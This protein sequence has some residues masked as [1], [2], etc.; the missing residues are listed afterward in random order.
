MDSHEET[1]DTFGDDKI[2]D[3]LSS[4]NSISHDDFVAQVSSPEASRQ[5][6][7]A[8]QLFNCI[9]NQWN[10]NP[11]LPHGETFFFDLLTPDQHLVRNSYKIFNEYVKSREGWSLKRREATPQERKLY[12]IRRKSKVYFIQAV[13]TVPL[14]GNTSTIAS[15]MSNGVQY[16]E[17]AS[18]AKSNNSAFSPARRPLGG[19]SARRL[20]DSTNAAAKP[21]QQKKAP[22]ASRGS[23]VGEDPTTLSQ[24]LD[25][26]HSFVPLVRTPARKKGSPP[27]L[28]RPRP[29][30]GSV[31][32]SPL[33]PYMPPP[34]MAASASHI[35][36]PILKAAPQQIFPGGFVYG[37][38]VRIDSQHHQ[39]HFT[40][41]DG[42]LSG[43][44]GIVVGQAPSASDRL[45]VSINTE[46]LEVAVQELK[47]L[48]GMPRWTSKVASPPLPD[49]RCHLPK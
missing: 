1:T 7:E 12:R 26:N 24:P 23:R 40:G 10:N 11:V 15:T 33:S 35:S 29:L 32:T 47:L 22:K 39:D 2:A 34:Q 30:A 44:R 31:M 21:K 6:V 9:Y 38:I 14:E 8:Y 16:Y 43:Q 17:E 13:Y 28:R 48:K 3:S 27:L 42:T 19:G 37:D 36:N 18:F 41:A 46:R 20:Y 5:C 45:I 25:P 49:G 4:A